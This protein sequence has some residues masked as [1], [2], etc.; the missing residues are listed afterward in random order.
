MVSVAAAQVYYEPAKPFPANPEAQPGEVSGRAAD[1]LDIT[2]VT[3]TR[4]I[5]TAYQKQIGVREE[6][7]AAAPALA[8]GA[9]VFHRRRRRLRARAAARAGFRETEVFRRQAVGPDLFLDI[10]N[11]IGDFLRADL[12]GFRQQFFGLFLQFEISCHWDFLGVLCTQ[13]CKKQCTAPN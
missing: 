12:F 9:A 7:A 3:G 13:L 1:T 5:E 8:I 10:G 11:R 4:V 2:D 6:N